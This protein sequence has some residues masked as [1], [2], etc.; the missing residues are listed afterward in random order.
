MI[1]FTSCD[2]FSFS[3]NKNLPVLDTIVDF[4]SVDTF[5]SFKNCDS[6]ITKQKK[7]D[8]FR[9]TIHLKI[10]EEI[11]KHQF[12]LKESISE[13]VYVDLIINTDGKIELQQITSNEKI[14]KNL[15]SLDSVLQNS[16]AKIPAIF[17]AI[18]RGIPVKS[19]Y[20]LPI[21]IELE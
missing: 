1:F 20:Q 14:K 16:I 19:K 5:P 11:Q 6:L 10:G 8:C 2:Y 17:P 4:S 21:K 9:T 15:P 7:A 13:T 12:T 18:K 3:K